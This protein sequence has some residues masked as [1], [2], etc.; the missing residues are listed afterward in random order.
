METRLCLSLSLSLSLSQTLSSLSS[1]SLISLSLSHLSRSS[2][3]LSLSLS[4]CLSLSLSEWRTEKER[5]QQH[6]LL[7]FVPAEHRLHPHDANRHPRSLGVQYE[8]AEEK[9]Q[10]D[11]V[12]LSNSLRASRRSDQFSQWAQLRVGVALAAVVVALHDGVHARHQVAPAL[13][14]AGSMPRQQLAGRRANDLLH[15]ARVPPYSRTH[16]AHTQ[17]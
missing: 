1:L 5:A 15:H 6:P 12:A 3:S 9:A 8:P 16:T 10:H 17:L 11:D 7:P 4:L 13:A 14:V 2:L